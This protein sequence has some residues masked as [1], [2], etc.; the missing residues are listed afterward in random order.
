MKQS[1][2]PLLQS[3]LRNLRK[4]AFLLKHNRLNNQTLQEL[5]QADALS[6]RKFLED[7]T[8]TMLVIGA[9]SVIPFTACNNAPDEQPLQNPK[10]RYK[11]N[12]PRKPRIV[13]IGGG[14]AG[15]NCAYTLYKNGIEFTIYEADRRVGGRILTHYN[16]SLGLGIF[17]EFGGDFIDSNH[18]DMF[19]LAK[20]FNL[21]L[22]DLIEEQKAQNLT[23]DIY[24]FE[25]RKISEKEVIK[26]FGKIAPKL[27]AD[28]ESLGENYDTE[29]AV[30]LDNTS[31]ETYINSLKCARW[32]KELLMAA[33]VAEF[34]LDCSEQSAINMLDM[35]NPDTS[36]GFEV[37][38]ESD[39]RYRIKN[40][41]S[42]IIEGIV[43]KIGADNIQKGYFLQQIEDA[44]N[45]TY[46]LTFAN[47]E[48]IYADFV[49][50]T[51]PFTILKN[52]QL[53]L[54]ALTPEKKKC[55]DELGYGMNTKLV[56]AYNGTPWSEK[57]NNAMGYL[58]HKEIANGWDSS[59]NKTENNPHGAYVCFYGGKYSEN[60]SKVSFK[61][62][63][64]PE[65]H[66]WRTELPDDLIDKTTT[67]LDK[68]FSGSKKKF[69]GKHVFVNW[70]DYPYVKASYSCYK[71]GQWTTIAGL[72]RQPIGNILFAGEHC[73]ENFQ[74]FM[75]GGAE[76]GRRAA[77]E[78][79]AKLSV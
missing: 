61:N 27:S 37:F 17:P 10:Y 33:Y 6:R 51:I 14:I 40:G 36:N 15:L 52:L 29:A 42:K 69:A 8:K 13:I 70:I 77:E 68:I 54:A 75:N 63:L 1:K 48:I 18:E 62:K 9:G 20:E 78:I 23:K 46:K 25:K 7:M 31:L 74:G 41:N 35:I 49:V 72:E 58:F 50:M 28:A 38:G 5:Q 19:K 76:T 67:E 47:N 24:F 53:N 32:L 55:I 22:I 45:N 65:T 12:T 59:Y 57:P 4:A 79:M 26:E 56:L 44:E 2:S 43:G 73:S 16:D 30:K 11:K 60:L 21:P 71:V 34:G 3:L 64:A 66:L 39:E